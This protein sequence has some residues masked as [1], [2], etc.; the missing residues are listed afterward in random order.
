[1]C[2]WVGGWMDGGKEGRRDL[3]PYGRPAFF[4]RRASKTR[5]DEG[6]RKRHADLDETRSGFER[7]RVDAMAWLGKGAVSSALSIGRRSPGTQGAGHASH[8]TV[9]AILTRI[10]RFS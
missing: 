5:N 9:R 2:G 8:R 3:P 6:R 4:L 10:S 7:E 1:M